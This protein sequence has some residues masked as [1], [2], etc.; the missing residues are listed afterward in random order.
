MN[1]VNL[2][3]RL[4][5]TP[6]LREVNRATSVATV[7]LA[8]AL[9]TVRVMSSSR[10]NG[11]T[12]PTT[13]AVCS[14]DTPTADSIAASMNSEAEDT[15][16]VPNAASAPVASITTSICASGPSPTDSSGSTTQRRPMEPPKRA[17]SVPAVTSSSPP[18][19]SS[20]RGSWSWRRVG[21]AAPR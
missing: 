19:T 4:T 21:R 2:V 11:S 13:S 10:S 5:R 18:G 8:D 12:S 14:G 7:R 9:G 3:G 1:N 6:E 16:A 17:V 20:A 15:G